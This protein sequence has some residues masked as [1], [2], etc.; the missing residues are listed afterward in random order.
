MYIYIIIKERENASIKHL[1]NYEEY[2]KLHDKENK[3]INDKH[4]VSP[5]KNYAFDLERSSLN[6]S[7]AKKLAI[8][9]INDTILEKG[10]F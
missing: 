4:S 1:K 6:K 7:Q 8:Y 2:K 3:A 9:N 5:V 10:I